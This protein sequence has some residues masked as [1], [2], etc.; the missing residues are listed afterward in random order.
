MA[1]TGK[2]VLAHGG[3]GKLSH[4]LV[5]DHIVDAFGNSGRAGENGLAS[6]DDAALVTVGPTRLAFTTDS[7]VVK[8]LFFPGGDIGKLAVCGTTNDLA[9]MGAEPLFLSCG[10]I[11]EEGFS[12]KML[13]RILDSMA[14]AAEAAEVGIVT[15]DT[16][17]VERGSADQLFVNTSGIGRI[18]ASV[19]VSTAQ[20]RVGD[21]IVVS[22]TLG[23]HGMAVMSA[24]EELHFHGTLE[25]DCAA[26]GG[27]IAR[28]IE[29]SSG[30]RFMRDP[31][32][33]G[34][35]STLNEMVQGRDFGIVIE[36]NTLPIRD[37]VRGLCELLGMDPLYVANEGKVV[38]VV[39]PE[40]A[41]ALVEAMRDHPLGREA[42][43]IGTVEDRWKGRVGLKTAVGGPRVVDMLVGDQLPRIC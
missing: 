43:L 41:D 26:L 7:Y 6:L 27:L 22:G 3:G 9:V 34:L 15:G 10:L 35:A 40:D 30:I 19:T 2:V 33:G 14:R 31:T 1:D 36:E 5:R 25:S 12:L 32:R 17:V 20:I 4:D 13:D 24:R 18:R 11:V 8:P 38:T 23:D 28:M 42:C 29:V 37:S 21:R 16:K 39:A